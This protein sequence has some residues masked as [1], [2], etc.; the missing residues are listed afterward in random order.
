MS[1]VLLRQGKRGLDLSS[2]CVYL[3]PNIVLIWMLWKMMIHTSEVLHLQ[4]VMTLRSLFL[5][6]VLPVA[7]G[8]VWCEQHFATCSQALVV[9][10]TWLGFSG[11]CCSVLV[12]AGTE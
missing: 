12:S 1:L 9:T 10:M 2:R 5:A 11:R 7:V 6:V 8:S 3:V 4:L